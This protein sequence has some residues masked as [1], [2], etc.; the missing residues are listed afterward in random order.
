MRGKMIIVGSVT[1]AMK[2]KDILFHEGIKAYVERTQRTKEYGCGYGVVVPQNADL[3]VKLM[4]Q[5]NIKIMAVI[6]AE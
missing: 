4:K 1:Y 2:S 3:A 5:N 6:D